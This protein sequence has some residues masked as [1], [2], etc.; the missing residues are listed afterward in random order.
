M[1]TFDKSDK[2]SDN[3]QTGS[4]ECAFFDYRVWIG[5]T[6]AGTVTGLEHATKLADSY[7]NKGYKDVYIER[8]ESISQPRDNE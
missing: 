1:A 6:K 3:S 5:E 7:A 2:S 4:C 8:L